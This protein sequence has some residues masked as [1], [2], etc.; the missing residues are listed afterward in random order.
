MERGG[1]GSNRN[2][3]GVHLLTLYVER[4]TNGTRQSQPMGWRSRERSAE[5][6]PAYIYGNNRE[7]HAKMNL[8][9]WSNRR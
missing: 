6:A 1:R 4:T 8:A 9:K 7:E 5:T 3:L 2:Q